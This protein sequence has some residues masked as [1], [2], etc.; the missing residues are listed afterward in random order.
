V[1]HLPEFSVDP[2]KAE[3]E[4]RKHHSDARAKDGFVKDTGEEG[5][6]MWVPVLNTASAAARLARASTK[7]LCTT[8]TPVKDRVRDLWAQ[9]DL[10]EPNA[11]GNAT[12]WLTRYADRK[13]GIYGGFDTTGS[14]NLDELNARL[15]QVAHILAY[16]ETHRQ[17]PKKRRQSVY[18]APEDQCSPAAGYPAELREAKKRGAG[19]MLEVRLAQAASKK[20]KAVLDMV[21]DHVS[22]KHKVVIFTGRKRD[23]DQL[24][25]DVRK[26]VSK[27]MQ[28]AALKSL[29]DV[30]VW[31]AHGEQTV[32]HRQGII[33]AYMEHPGP[34]VL[35]GTGHAFGE[36]LNI[37]D[38]DAAFFVMLP[39]TPGQLRQW[40]G[41]FTRLGQTRPVVI[42]YVIAED[43][44][45]E[46]IAS[47]L[48]DKLPAVQKIAKDGELAEAKD[49]LAGFDPNQ[50]EDEFVD[51]ILADLDFS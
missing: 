27:L 6:K 5:W 20:R 15:G 12:T 35:V 37:H 19:A 29:G 2:E 23:C 39:Y 36:S 45:D 30:A 7:R 49:V 25:H 22:S 18:L 34:C 9:L 13:P 26:S 16:E 21:I 14:S 47:I 41:R 32:K 40:E 8:A 51:S 33:D 50:T 31:S 11:W 48:I 28:L 38:T 46:H 4:L 1:V 42:Y 24:G 44:V 3:E 17:L 43:T 10:A